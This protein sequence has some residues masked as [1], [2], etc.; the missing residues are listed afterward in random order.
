MTE[1]DERGWDY[2]L[3]WDEG[4]AR[5][6]SVY[7]RPK[8]TKAKARSR[9]RLFKQGHELEKKARRPKKVKELATE[10]ADLIEQARLLGIQ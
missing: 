10:L 8:A 1:P 2:H 6:R 4:D 5:E 3:R 9:K 7:Y